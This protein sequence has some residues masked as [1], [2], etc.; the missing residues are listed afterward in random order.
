MSGNC[1][2]LRR[3]TPRHRAAATGYFRKRGIN[4]AEALRQMEQQ[5]KWSG[6]AVSVV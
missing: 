2:V 6:E 5:S 1:G 3:S 4:F